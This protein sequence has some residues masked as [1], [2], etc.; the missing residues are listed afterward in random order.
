M[1]LRRYVS[2]SPFNSRQPRNPSREIL[3]NPRSSDGAWTLQQPRTTYLM[4][5]DVAQFSYLVESQTLIQ[6][7]QGAVYNG[8]SNCRILVVFIFPDI[9]VF[10]HRSHKPLHLTIYTTLAIKHF[11]LDKTQPIFRAIKHIHHV[12]KDLD[13][14][15]SHRQPRRQHTFRRPQQSFVSIQV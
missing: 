11:T 10:D 8:R 5:P 7:I 1:W 2:I 15:W 12:E 3:T 6:L 14:L 9:P 4:L 13:H